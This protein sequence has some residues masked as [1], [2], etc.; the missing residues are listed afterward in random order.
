MGEGYW[1]FWS[2]SLL[3]G[4]SVIGRTWHPRLLSFFFN[5]LAFIT[6]WCETSWANGSHLLQGQIRKP[7]VFQI[8]G[9]AMIFSETSRSPR[10]HPYV[11][12]Y[13]FTMGNLPEV[14]GG[15]P[16]FL[17]EAVCNGSLRQLQRSARI[18]ASFRR[19]AQ[20]LNNQQPT[21]SNWKNGHI[22]LF[23]DS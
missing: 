3:C 16:R 21:T 23:Q 6:T 1:H 14:S 22:W 19:W 20:L 18:P 10:R 4:I 12:R 15:F 9:W 11:T 17:R 8:V 7:A 13:N 2:C 5:Y